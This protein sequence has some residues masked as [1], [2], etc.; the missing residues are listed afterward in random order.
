MSCT[1]EDKR[2][3]YNKF[4]KG[5]SHRVGFRDL[6]KLNKMTDEERLE[7][8]KQHRDNIIEHFNRRIA[9]AESELRCCKDF[10][11]YYAKDEMLDG[12]GEIVVPEAKGKGGHYMLSEE[13]IAYFAKEDEVKDALD[14]IV[15]TA[16]NDEVFKQVLLDKL[17]E[18]K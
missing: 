3:I 5:G 13:E 6:F 17:G 15:G 4:Y 11:A 16:A 14:I 8:R 7:F 18:I 9:R 10:A 2:A 12:A 1:T